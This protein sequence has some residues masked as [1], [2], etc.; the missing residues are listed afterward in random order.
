VEQRLD[1][2][3]DHLLKRPPWWLRHD[4]GRCWSTRRSAA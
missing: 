3:L 2:V 4:R 1:R